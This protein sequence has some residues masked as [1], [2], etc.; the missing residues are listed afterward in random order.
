[1]LRLMLNAHPDLAIPPETYFINAGFRAWKNAGEGAE[2][3]IDALVEAVTAHPR[4]STVGIEADAFAARVR[5]RAAREPGDALR[6]FYELYAERAGKPRWGDKTPRYGRRLRFIH[7]LLPEVRFIHLIRDGRA[8]ARSIL[9]LWI[10]PGTIEECAEWWVEGVDRAREHARDVPHYMEVI[11]ED[12]VRDPEPNLRRIAEFIEVPFD[13]R[14]VRYYEIPRVRS[15]SL[16]ASVSPAGV[17]VRPEDRAGVG[18]GLDRPP[19]PALIDRW[20]AEL[21]PE[22]ITAFDAIAGERLRELGYPVGA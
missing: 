3:A 16:R 1:M 14:M 19:D 5:D 4:W 22:Q 15:E 7:R 10:G 6:C 13:E 8:V 11:Y 17:R 18:Q 21:S 12:L 9:N 2:D 20:R